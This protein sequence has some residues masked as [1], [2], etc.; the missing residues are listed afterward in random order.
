MLTVPLTLQHLQMHPV[1]VR[2]VLAVA[3]PAPGPDPRYFLSLYP[4]LALVYNEPQTVPHIFSPFLSPHIHQHTPPKLT[5]T[6]DRKTSTDPITPCNTLS[7]NTLAG[8]AT[9]S[10]PPVSPNTPNT[11]HTP[12]P[13]SPRQT[14]HPATPSTTSQRT[15]PAPIN[16]SSP[17][18]PRSNH[19]KVY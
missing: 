14:L 19:S 16:C 10:K 5:L 2:S 13:Q 17:A 6:Q 8:S 18:S 4:L 11:L 15:A 12:I 3:R 9:P 7:R 1:H